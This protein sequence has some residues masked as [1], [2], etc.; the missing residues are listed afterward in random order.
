MQSP[1]CF[2]PIFWTK[3]MIVVKLFENS[4]NVHKIISFW[5]LALSFKN[6][7]WNFQ[8]KIKVWFWFCLPNLLYLFSNPFYKS[9]YA[10]RSKKGR[11]KFLNQLW[12][13]MSTSTFTPLGQVET[14]IFD[15]PFGCAKA[16]WGQA[17]PRAFGYGWITWKEGVGSS[18]GQ[19][20]VERVFGSCGWFPCVCGST[21]G[22]HNIEPRDSQTDELYCGRFGCHQHCPKWGFCQRN[23]QGEAAKLFCREG[24]QN[25]ASAAV[26]VPNRG[27]YG[28]IMPQ[29]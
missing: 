21:K 16:K 7:K 26:V 10:L 8:N 4:Q 24:D 25:Q 18:K 13:R 11:K 17:N 20:V 28:N 9:K 2:K 6:W 29:N 5:I 1:K 15:C 14:W 22:S 12:S 3:L 27:V 19:K 23:F